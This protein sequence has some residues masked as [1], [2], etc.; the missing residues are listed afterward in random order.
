MTTTHTTERIAVEVPEGQDA[1]V[2][3]LGANR[4]ARAKRCNDERGRISWVGLVWSNRVLKAHNWLVLLLALSYTGRG[5]ASEA[6]QYLADDK[7]KHAAVGAILGVCGALLVE[8]LIPDAPKP[9]KFLVAILP[10]VAAGAL[11]EAYDH[12]HP[13][14]HTCDAR[15]FIA[16]TAGGLAG[17]GISLEIAWHF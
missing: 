17:A 11:K 6:D 5:I 4:A 2:V 14:S 12:R 7:A 10:A 1:F 15:D 3:E 13:E 16:T 8:R 9:V